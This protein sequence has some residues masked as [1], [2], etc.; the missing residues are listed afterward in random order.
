M[1]EQASI[2]S[3]MHSLLNPSAPGATWP[4]SL[5]L[6]D[7]SH[8]MQQD[9][10]PQVGIKKADDESSLEDLKKNL[11]VVSRCPHTDRKHYAKNM[12][13]NCYHK[14]G[15]EKLAWLCPH[16]RRPHYAKGKCH[17]CY[18]SM[19]KRMSAL[20]AKSKGPSHS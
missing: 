12:C 20:R 16:V 6:P 11:M 9:E 13:C 4:I 14:S 19:R 2:F 5:E 8:L 1:S 17:V 15:R 18:L 10:R 3:N 7:I